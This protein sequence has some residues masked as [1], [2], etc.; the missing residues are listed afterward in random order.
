MILSAFL[1]QNPSR[2]DIT[3][4]VLSHPCHNIQWHTIHVR[5]RFICHCSVLTGY[6]RNKSILR[7]NQLTGPHR[8]SKLVLK[9]SNTEPSYLTDLDSPAVPPLPSPPSY[10][11]PPPPPE[12]APRKLSLPLYPHPQPIVP[13]LPQPNLRQLSRAQSSLA[14]F[15]P[16]VP[17]PTQSSGLVMRHA[18]RTRAATSP[19]STVRGVIGR[20]QTD[21][22]NMN[23]DLLQPRVPTGPRLRQIQDAKN[24][25]MTV[26]DR[27]RKKGVDFPDYEFLE[28]IGK[29]NYGRVYKR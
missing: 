16:P 7:N 6:M 26:E 4:I 2:P 8:I 25:Q 10:A 12:L 3:T 29:G 13:I 22:E 5:S 14:I 1:L 28:L 19:T 15:Y 9:R 21:I 24:M 18:W 23:S 20:S 11:V 17:I 27:C